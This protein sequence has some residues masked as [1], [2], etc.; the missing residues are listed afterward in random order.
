MYITL[1]TNYLPLKR[2]ARLR[3]LETGPDWVLVSSRGKNI[4]IPQ[5]LT[6]SSSRQVTPKLPESFEEEADSIFFM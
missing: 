1:N 4:Y 5:G 2:G 6:T 3:V